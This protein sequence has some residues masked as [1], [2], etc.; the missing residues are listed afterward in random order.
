[1]V[2]RPSSMVTF[3]CS[4]P[5]MP[6][7]ITLNLY[8]GSSLEKMYL[9]PAGRYSTSWLRVKKLLFSSFLFFA[10]RHLLTSFPTTGFPLP[11]PINVYLFREA[12]QELRVVPRKNREVVGHP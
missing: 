11:D 5:I 1:M 6:E 8:L 4:R 3:I 9:S 10:I 12:A 7:P 2:P